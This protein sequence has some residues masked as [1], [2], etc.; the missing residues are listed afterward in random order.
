MVKIGL[1]IPTLNAGNNFEILLNSVEMQKCNF[2]RK[3]IIDSG[4]NDGTLE[5]AQKYKYEILSIS[6]ASFNHGGTRQQAI[7]QLD[8]IDIAVFLTQDVI[9]YNDTSVFNLVKILDNKEVGAVY[10]RQ[11]PYPT[12]S[13]LSAQARLF[14]YP[15]KSEIK[16]YLDKNRLGIK[17][18]FL[19]DS[20]AAY[21]CSVLKEVGG[22]PKKVIIAEDM[23]VTAKMLLNSYKIAY[24]AEACVYHSHDYNLLQEFRR[25][26]DTG[27]FQAR[28][29]W[30]RNA[31]GNAEGE[32]LKLMKDQM[33][34]LYEKRAYSDIVRAALVNIVKLIGYRVGILEKYLPIWLK[35]IC[36]GQSYFFSRE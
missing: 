10:G 7:E 13:L 29:A 9:L 21:R 15:D 28:E 30:I 12:A 27:V 18:A 35:K 11:L 8:D 23:Y 4:S 16:S 1:I 5:I 25:Y 6:K 2:Y 31:F 22:F 14:N 17:T 36:S 24:I 3:L 32:G 19:S 33:R 20:F 26:F 34:Y